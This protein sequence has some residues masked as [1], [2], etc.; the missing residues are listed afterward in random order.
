MAI[1]I[2]STKE[3]WFEE[4]AKRI[5]LALETKNTKKKDSKRA[6]VVYFD[7]EIILNEFKKSDHC[8]R[9]NWHKIDVLTEKHN[10]Y[11]KN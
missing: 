4:I 1:D 3:L 9:Y 11:E 7:N 10:D 8:R 2:L 5:N 6:V